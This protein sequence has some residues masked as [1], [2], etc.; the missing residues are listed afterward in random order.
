ML[1]WQGYR[2][3]VRT[4]GAQGAAKLPGATDPRSEFETWNTWNSRPFGLTV[5]DLGGD[6]PQK[7]PTCFLP[8]RNCLL[9]DHGVDRGSIYPESGS[10]GP[11]GATPNKHSD[12]SF[13]VQES[14]AAPASSFFTLELRKSPDT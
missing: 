9:K 10:K 5:F 8:A 7:W 13:K 12:L 14:A 2:R 6:T 4:G 11:E 1:R 3:L